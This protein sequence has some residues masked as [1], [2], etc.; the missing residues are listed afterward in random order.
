[1]S[2]LKE[3]I[4]SRHYIGTHLNVPLY[5]HGTT[6]ALIAF[7]LLCEL[8]TGLVSTLYLA[9]TILCIALC[10]TLHEYGH[11]KAAQSFG[12]F[13]RDV[14]LY[15][16][17]GMAVI[18]ETQTSSETVLVSIAG[19]AVNFL[20]ASIA[21]PLV[22]L[23]SFNEGLARIPATFVAVNLVLGVF[24]M[25]PAYPMDGGRIFQGAIWHFKGYHVATRW[26]VNLS[27]Y[28]I[29]PIFIVVGL[30]SANLIL[31]VIG[32]LVLWQ[33]HQNSNPNEII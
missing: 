3:L 31:A 24:N 2:R 9:W 28:V 33:C 32:G 17:G 13:T 14:T 5:V 19:P 20:C 23:L 15:P 16:I 11:I 6:L 12:I 18:G 26:A 27:K 4:L 22:V 10:V 21:I 8:S 30:L 29:A 1:M 7:V 25:I